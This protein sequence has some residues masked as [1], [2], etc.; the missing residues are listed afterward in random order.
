MCFRLDQLLVGFLCFL[1][2]P[3]NLIGRT[4]FGLK[5]SWVGSCPPS[6]TKSSTWLQEVTTSPFLNTLNSFLK[7]VWS[8]VS[9]FSSFT[10]LISYKSSYVVC[11]AKFYFYF[12]VLHLQFTSSC[13][14]SV[15]YEVDTYSILWLLKTCVYEFPNTSS[16]GT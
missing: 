14:R 3:V 11:V 12:Q 16:I 13:G 9:L 5:V 7:L 15:P 1:F 2:F 4:N 8:P 6:S 10:L